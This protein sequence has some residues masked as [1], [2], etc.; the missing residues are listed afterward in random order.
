LIEIGTMYC[1]APPPWPLE[2]DACV[3]VNIGTS[4]LSDTSAPVLLER[5]NATPISP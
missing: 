5:R 3:S 2:S 1:V 4:A